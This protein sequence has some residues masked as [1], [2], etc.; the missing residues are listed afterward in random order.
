MLNLLSCKKTNLFFVFSM[1]LYAV[2]FAQFPDFPTDS[3]TNIED[4]NQMMWQLGI[5]FPDLPSKLNDTN[6]NP[7]FVP[8]DS[9]NSE[10]NWKDIDNH[11][12]TRTGFGLWNNYD[13][14]KVVEYTPINLLEMNHGSLISTSDEWFENRR[15]EVWK[16]V[17]EQV[18]GVIPDESLLP[19]V[20]FTTIENNGGEGDKAYIEKEILGTIDITS[21]PE[22]RNIPKI[23][24][25]VRLPANSKNAPLMI[26]FTSRR[27]SNMDN[28]WNE[29]VPQGWGVCFFYLSDLQPD[30]GTFLTSYLIGLVNKGNWR[31]PTDWGTLAAWSWGVSRLIDYFETDAAVNAKQIGITGH[32]RYGKA[33]LVTMAYEPR[34]AIGFPSCAGAL[35]TSM[36]RRH[37]AQDLENISWDREYHWVAGNFFKWMGSLNEGEYLPR[38][39][40]NMPVDAH[41]LLALCAPRPVFL[42]GGTQDSWTDSYGIYLTGVGATPVYDLI[43]AKGLVMEDGKPVVD[44]SY[45]EGDIAYRK[46][47]GGHTP[48][49]D[50]ESFFKFASKY[51]KID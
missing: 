18:W 2:S 12:I 37:L 21:Y 15:P 41:S 13:E 43:G 6:A 45:D 24:A 31:T 11:L 3:V 34:L 20:T 14:T 25:T 50:W 23:T 46:H 33:T 8:S 30:N 48:Q 17:T 22:V 49:P 28:F 10:G 29:N 9:L 40:E 44:V 32:S 16:D 36:V 39:V 1:L 38:K 42:N 51:I 47:E 4:R 26:M 27:F 5:S 35:G 7:T 19:S